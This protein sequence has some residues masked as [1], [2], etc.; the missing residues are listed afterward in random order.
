LA[1]GFKVETFLGF[2]RHWGQGTLEGLGTSLILIYSL[3]IGIIYLGRK[4]ILTGVNGT[5][6]VKIPFKLLG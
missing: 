4:G 5:L 6:K 1:R 3:A 2:P